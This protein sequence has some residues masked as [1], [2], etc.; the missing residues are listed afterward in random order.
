MRENFLADK[1]ISEEKEDKFQ[2][3]RFSKRIAETIVNRISIDSIVIGLYGA[4]GEGKTSVLNFI[5]K[6]LDS[7]QTNIIHFTFNPWRFT[8][9]TTLLTSFFNMLATELK[10]SFVD[11][12]P[13]KGK[14]IFSKWYNNKKG[15]LKTDREAIGDLIQEYAKVASILGAS[16]VVETVGKAI[17]DGNIE[18]LKARIEKLLKDHQK[19][20][21]IF[22]DDIDRLE[23]NEIQS[24]FRLVKLTG[25]FAYTTYVLSFDENMVA[26]AIAE[27]FGTGDQKAGL[28]F[29]EK[30]IQIPL[31]LPLAQKTALINYC[32][33]LVNQSL[34]SSEIILTSE[35]EMEFSK[36]FSSNFLLR[37]NTPRLAVR[38]GNSISF[39][40]P[41]LK[42]EVN[43]VD[44]LLIEAFR[45]FYPEFYDFIR[46][47][48]DYF[49]GTYPTEQS[50]TSTLN[51]TKNDKFK[52]MF[53][54]C[55]K[56]YNS[57]EIKN[58]QDAMVDLFPNVQTVL[59]VRRFGVGNEER[60]YN[61][62]RISTNQYFNR[63][64]SYVV[65]DGDISDV[66]FSDFLAN[67]TER[68]FQENI[69]EAICL[70]K[71]STPANFVQKFRFKEK[72]LESDISIS[73]IRVITQLGDQFPEGKGAFGGWTN[74]RSQASIFISQL[75]RNQVIEDEKFGLVKWIITNAAPFQF[76]TEIF[77]NCQVVNEERNDLFTKEQYA[78][79]SSNLISRAKS[80]SLNKPIWESYILESY[81]IMNI[82]ANNFD[83]QD[84]KDYVEEQLNIF[85]ES[86]ASLLKG[87][88]G[89][90]YSS[91]WPLPYFG[92]LK[93]NTYDWVERILD[94]NFIY[95][96]IGEVLKIDLFIINEYNELKHMQT[97]EN[98]MKQFAYWHN[99]KENLISPVVEVEI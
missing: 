11:E 78:E 94:T 22:I 2:R 68:D 79:L 17:S 33:E 29:L 57:D 14:N 35:E 97:D 92:D 42:G 48:P 6:E 90:T 1:P 71:S 77:S 65:I 54:D 45:V 74:P 67:I 15:D 72:I 27:R 38:Y 62:K 12:N 31:K 82:W 4:W 73:L 52:K 39:S 34:E 19:K 87:F 24:I 47:K 9:E 53:D 28:N 50:S 20:V 8:D 59:N 83:K 51:L 89:Y 55:S 37:L 46:D 91:A 30:I 86:I 70:I 7:H 44:L 23:K 40:L 66:A 88:V 75:I 3:Y 16:D 49:I 96:K 60:R 85:P 43:Y 25:D 69:K 98:M 76:A 41:L 32:F 95:K 81:S 13:A 58:V 63:Y 61:D 36:K 84:L 80:L 18:K 10:E 93:K 64:F 21:V 56:L 5:K 26:S 99:K